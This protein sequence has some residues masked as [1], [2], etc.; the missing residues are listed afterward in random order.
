MTELMIQIMRNAAR[1]SDVG[2]RLLCNFIYGG[3]KASI[4][5]FLKTNEILSCFELGIKVIDEKNQFYNTTE[6]ISTGKK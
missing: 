4:P 2:D 6:E 5:I 3:K 1:P